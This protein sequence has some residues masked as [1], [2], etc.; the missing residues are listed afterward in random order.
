M[1]FKNVE[2]SVKRFLHGLLTL[3]YRNFKFALQP[4]YERRINPDLVFDCYV[5]AS[6]NAL[7]LLK[8]KRGIGFVRLKNIWFIIDNKTNSDMYNFRFF[9]TSNASLPDAV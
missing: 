4:L 2:I 8:I 5:A 6:I 7:N 3:D 1:I 9:D